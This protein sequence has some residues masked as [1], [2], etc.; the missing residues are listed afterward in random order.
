MVDLEGWGLKRRRILWLRYCGGIY[1]EAERIMTKGLQNWTF[2]EQTSDCLEKQLM[3]LDVR[4]VIAV[5]HKIGQLPRF[6]P[7]YRSRGVV[8]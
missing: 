8:L 7:T 2:R 6:A 3:V 5:F 4:V 1:L